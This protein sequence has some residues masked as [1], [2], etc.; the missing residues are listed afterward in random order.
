MDR[1]RYRGLSDRKINVYMDIWLD[2]QL[3][4]KRG[5]LE[6]RSTEGQRGKQKDKQRST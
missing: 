4:T 3:D 5:R 6:S 2:G 1:Q